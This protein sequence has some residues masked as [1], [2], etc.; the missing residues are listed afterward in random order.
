MPIPVILRTFALRVSLV[1]AMLV[2]GVTFAFGGMAAYFLAVGGPQRLRAELSGEVAARR[3][4]TGER[5][6][7]APIIVAVLCL[8]VGMGVGIGAWKKAARKA[9][10]EHNEIGRV[11]G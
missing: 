9:G 3:R 11:F 1:A 8:S 2:V 4:A 6:P 10:L 5:L 7:S